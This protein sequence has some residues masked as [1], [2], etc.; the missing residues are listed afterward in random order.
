MFKVY[1]WTGKEMTYYGEHDTF[2]E[3]WDSIY[4]EFR[5]LDDAA[6]DEQLGKFHVEEIEDDE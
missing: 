1:D 4:D 2:E 6:L 5:D 3:A